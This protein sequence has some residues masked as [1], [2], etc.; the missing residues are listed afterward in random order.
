MKIFIISLSLLSILSTKAMNQESQPLKSP[1]SQQQSPMRN[2]PELQNSG[3]LNRFNRDKKRG[4]DRN[5]K[6]IISLTAIYADMLDI[7][8]QEPPLKI[9][10]FQ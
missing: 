5:E 9:Q 7:S 3:R 2:S 4:L 8:C 6:R 10:R 1:D